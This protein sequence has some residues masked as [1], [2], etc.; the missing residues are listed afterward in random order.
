MNGLYKFIEQEIER[1]ATSQE[2]TRF[3]MRQAAALHA[4]HNSIDSA[5]LSSI[6]SLEEPKQAF[7]T[8]VSQH[9][10]DNGIVTANTLTELFS[11]KY[12]TSIGITNY[13]ARVQDLH[14]KIRDL[15]AGDKGLQLSNRLFAILLVNSLPRNEF[16][17]II[18]HFLSNIKSISTSDVCARL[19]LEA[20]SYSNNEEKFKEVY[21]VKSKKTFR[22]DNRRVGKSPKDLCHIHPNSKHTNKQCHTQ[23]KNNPKESSSPSTEE[24][25]RRYQA[26]MATSSQSTPTNLNPV[27]AHVAIENPS[28]DDFITYAA[29]TTC[30]VLS[31]SGLRHAVAAPGPT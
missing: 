7:K 12:D 25:A 31:F 14:S 3:N 28:S 24:M 11:L 22:N 30:N 27:S 4:I 5:N 20:N 29:Y 15:T 1:P 19:R 2:R 6:E 10:S 26:M 16:R 8:L 17:L 18:K 9:G 21:T 13:I 23:K